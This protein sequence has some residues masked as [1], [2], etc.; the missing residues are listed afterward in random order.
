MA[1]NLDNTI[2]RPEERPNG[3][4]GYIMRLINNKADKNHTH[5][6]ADITDFYTHNHDDRYY[7]KEEH[8]LCLW[9]SGNGNPDNQMGEDGDFYIDTLHK[10]LWEK[11]GTEWVA[12][13]SME[14]PQGIQGPQGIPGVTGQ[15]GPIGPKGPQGPQG[16]PGQRGLPGADGE[17]AYTAARKGGFS[18]TQQEFYT[19]LASIGDIND[20]L[21]EINGE[22]V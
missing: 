13:F 11:K 15:T 17:S 19:S 9:Y 4:M 1:I 2:F 21:D 16:D 14:G 6:I 10:L 20:V 22:V 8:E 12:Q 18:G 7:L 5:V 3:I